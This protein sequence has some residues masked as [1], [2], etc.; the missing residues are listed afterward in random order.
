MRKSIPCG[1]FF[2]VCSLFPEPF[3]AARQAVPIRCS[4]SR[5]Y[6]A[7]RAEVVS[8]YGHKIGLTVLIFFAPYASREFCKAESQAI[9]A[10][11]SATA[12]VSG[13]ASAS[14]TAV[15][16]GMASADLIPAV[17]TMAEIL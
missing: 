15:V 2:R 17:E 13:M 11:A 8:G 16:S 9:E 12:V 14:A 10:S 7:S 5:E 6:T 3:R 1:T 4:A